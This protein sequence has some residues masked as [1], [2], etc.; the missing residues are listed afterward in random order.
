MDTNRLS[1]IPVDCD[2]KPLRAM[3]R[4]ATNKAKVVPKDYEN[5]SLLSGAYARLLQGYRSR[6]GRDL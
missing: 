6:S 3:V 5:L 1:E 4:I 2:G